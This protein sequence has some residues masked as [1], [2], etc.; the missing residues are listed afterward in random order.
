MLLLCRFLSGYK[1]MVDRRLPAYSIMPFMSVL[2]FFLFG[3]MEVVWNPGQ[4]ILAL[5]FFMQ[6]PQFGTTCGWNI[7]KVVGEKDD[8]GRKKETEIP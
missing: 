3:L 1:I 5:V 8:G 6:H 7:S 4:L 2:L